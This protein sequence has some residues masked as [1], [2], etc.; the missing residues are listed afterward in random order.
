TLVMIRLGRVHEGLMVDMQAINAKLVARSEN[1]LRRLSGRSE[2]EV[3]DAL[4]RAGGNVKKALL[5]LHGCT[6]QKADAL[7][8]EYGGRWRLA[9]RLVGGASAAVSENLPLDADFASAVP[10]KTE[11]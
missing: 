11:E 7:V 8:E 3:R 9:L 1:I 6:A 10:G 2:N 5:I 4:Q